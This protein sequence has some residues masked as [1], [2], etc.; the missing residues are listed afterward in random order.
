MKKAICFLCILTVAVSTLCACK[1]E[2]K[3]APAENST[4]SKTS[5]NLDSEYELGNESFTTVFETDGKRDVVHIDEF[6]DD[7]MIEHCDS[8]GVVIYYEEPV[9]KANGDVKAYK[10][11]DSNKNWIATLDTNNNFY[12]TEGNSITESDFEKMISK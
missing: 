4:T 5:V 2:T 3:E 10:L 11:Y 9:Y 7:M 1:K 8:N 6:G 12:D